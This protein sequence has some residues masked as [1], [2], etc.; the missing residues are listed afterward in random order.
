MRY[1]PKLRRY[2]AYTRGIDRELVKIPLRAYN[3]ADAVGRAV[4]QCEG[5]R[6][7]V[8][9][10]RDVS[11]SMVYILA[12]VTDDEDNGREVWVNPLITH[13]ATDPSELYLLDRERGWV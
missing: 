5:L 3:D 8:A 6:A 10:V 13:G 1:A 4:Y 2:T 12:E 9:P 11:R 7:L